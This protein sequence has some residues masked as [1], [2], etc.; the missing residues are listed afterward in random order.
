[1]MGRIYIRQFQLIGPPVRNFG[2]R[3][4]E[5]RTQCGHRLWQGIGEIA[6]AAAAIS[7]VRHDNFLAEHVLWAAPKVRQGGAACRVQQSGNDGCAMMIQRGEI[8]FHAS[9]AQQTAGMVLSSSVDSASI[10]KSD[11]SL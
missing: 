5:R 3:G 4:I 6:V 10:V 11:T 8:R 2:E 9:P 1:M 7:M